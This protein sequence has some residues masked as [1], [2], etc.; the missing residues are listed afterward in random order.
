VPQAIDD[1]PRISPSDLWNRIQAGEAMLIV[2]ARSLEV[3]ELEHIVGAVS[4]PR[5]E[6]TQRVSEIPKDKLIVFY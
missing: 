2:D 3:Y 4:I 1:I 6:V 5:E